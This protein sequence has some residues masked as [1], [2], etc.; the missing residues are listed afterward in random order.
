MGTFGPLYASNSASLYMLT[1]SLAII[2]PPEC[3]H[4]HLADDMKLVEHDRGIARVLPHPFDVGVLFALTIRYKLS[5]V[6]LVRN[7]TDAV[8]GNFLT[9]FAALRWSVRQNMRSGKPSALSNPQHLTPKI[10]ILREAD[11]GQKTIQE[12]LPGGK[13]L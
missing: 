7:N 5:E 12:I 1:M 8:S 2:S 10:R 3:S 9:L 11:C 13:P 4:N 6:R